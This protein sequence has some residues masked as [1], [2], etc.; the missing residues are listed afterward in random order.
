MEG[1]TCFE[2]EVCDPGPFVPPIL[3]YSHAEGCSVPG[4]YV[5]RGDAIPELQGHYFY[6]DFCSGFLRS[7][8]ADGS[9]REWTEQTG[10][11][12][13]VAGFGIGGDGEMY[14]VSHG[15]SLYLVEGRR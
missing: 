8:T 13:Q 2:N 1:T 4:G 15:G 12:A 7:V 11:T 5:Y 14:V 3:E 6:S 9:T 10:E